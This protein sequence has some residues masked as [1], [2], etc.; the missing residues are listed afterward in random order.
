MPT[1]NQYSFSNVTYIVPED[2]NVSGLHPTAVITLT[3]EPGYTL[4]ANSFSLDTSVYY[5]ELQ[6]VSFIQSG[7]NVICTAVFASNFVMPSNNVSI[8]L[9]IIGEGEIKKKQV[10]GRVF[11]IVGSFVEGYAPENHFY[12]Y[13]SESGSLGETELVFTKT[14]NA[15]DGY[16]LRAEIFMTEG[17]ETNYTIESLP[18]YDIDGNLI[19][20]TW[21]AYYLYPDY[22]S[23]G[24][25]W[26]LKVSGT[27]IYVAPQ[28]VTSYSFDQSPLLPTGET[29]SLTIF[30]REGAEFSLNMVEHFSGA[31]TNIATDI[32]LGAAGEYT[33][34]VVFPS[35]TNNFSLYRIF[36]TGDIDPEFSLANPIT[37]AQTNALIRANISGISLNGITGYTT[38]SAQGAAFASASNLFINTTWTLTSSDG[39]INY[40][41]NI[42]ETNFK[43]T[44]PVGNNTTVVSSVS[45]STTV[46]VVDATGIIIGDRFNINQPTGSN[47]APFMF[48]ITNITG[49]TLTVTPNITIE[50]GAFFEV[51]RT[52]GNIINN[53]TATATTI[54]PSTV[55]FNLSVQ[56]TQFGDRDA[57]FVLDLDEIIEYT[58]II[59]CGS[60]ATSGGPGITDEAITL[61]PAGGLL[62]FLINAQGVADKFEIMHGNNSGTKVATSSMTAIGN[63]GPFDN[64]YGTEIDNTLPTEPQAATVDQF[65]GSNKGIPI[66]TRQTEFNSETGYTIPAMNVGGIN[67][68]QVLWWEYTS[69]DYANNPIATLRV[70]GPLGTAWDLLRVC[71]PDGNCI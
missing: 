25:E 44:L 11:N 35:I 23:T 70:T 36:I 71:C 51:Y 19:S 10:G 20:I 17:S 39:V 12:T 30:G 63:S 50:A 56:V 69:A 47:R 37:I 7:L 59:S 52:N 45:D 21:N 48:E 28:Y 18:T 13:Y 9:C 65:I 53:V 1:I 66:P 34:Q 15:E 29:R 14:F 58:P 27:T 62:A 8:P 46:N 31:T 60:V 68:Q 24:D 6:S 32:T 5:P 57:D 41:G 67:Y 3:P 16:Y 43:F 38:E 33:T 22:D 42:N 64:V 2:S 54:D 40:L 61:D 26:T 49:N 4:D 55:E